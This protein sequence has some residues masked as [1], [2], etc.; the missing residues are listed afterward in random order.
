MAVNDDNSF[1]FFRLQLQQTMR[2]FRLKSSYAKM[3]GKLFE[4]K[5]DISPTI[6]QKI[7]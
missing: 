5:K 4:S 6:H 1:D 3:V 7:L 2:K